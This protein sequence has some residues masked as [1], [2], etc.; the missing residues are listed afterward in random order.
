MAGWM[1][2][3]PSSDAGLVL[4]GGLKSRAAARICFSWPHQ[5]TETFAKV[6]PDKTAASVA[7]RSK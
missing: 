2:R 1:S 3:L 7:G 4:G 6:Y 5:P